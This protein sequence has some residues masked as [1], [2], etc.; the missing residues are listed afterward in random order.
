MSAL[1]RA[2]RRLLAPKSVF[3]VIPLMMAASTAN[4]DQSWPREFAGSSP[5]EWSLRLADSEISR[6]GDSLA[7]KEGGRARWDYTAGLFTLSLL[8]LDERVHEPAY[9][10]FAQRAIGS[11]ISTNGDIQGY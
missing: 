1:K 10:N 2:L 5:L 9:V 7:W 3:L 6:R 4:A 8:K 11:F